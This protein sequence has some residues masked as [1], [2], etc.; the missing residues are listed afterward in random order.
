M[1]EKSMEKCLMIYSAICDIVQ[2]YGD[3]ELGTCEVDTTAVAKYCCSDKSVFDLL[4]CQTKEDIYAKFTQDILDGF[5]V[6]QFLKISDW[7][8]NMLA[9]NFENEAQE[10]LEKNKKIYKCLT[11]Q[12]YHEAYTSIGTF[13]TCECPQ[14]SCW[15][16]RR[17][18]LPQLK[19][20]CK[21]YKKLECLK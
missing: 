16:K 8:K 3:T 6:W 21:N 14:E 12:F 15:A 19:K 17:R 10:Q 4:E 5:A 1:N 13:V 9:R 2:I 11:C 18:S 7:T 20:S